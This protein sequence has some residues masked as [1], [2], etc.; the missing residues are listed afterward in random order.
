MSRTIT[1]PDWLH[2]AHAGEMLASEFIEPLGLDAVR[3]AHAVGVHVEQI[4]AVVAGARPVDAELT[5]AWRVISACRRA[6]SSASRRTT[7]YSR[8]SAP[9]MVTWIVSSRGQHDPPVM[10]NL[11][12][13][14][15]L[16]LPG[17]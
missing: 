5:C 7:S 10:L 15:V 14:P 3:L 17:G 12:Q 1:N 13:Y 6:F 16:H 9:S 2:N 8:P 11:F 4:E